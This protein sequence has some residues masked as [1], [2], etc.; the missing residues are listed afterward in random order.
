MAVTGGKPRCEEYVRIA[1]ITAARIQLALRDLSSVGRSEAETAFISEDAENWYIEGELSDMAQSLDCRMKHVAADLRKD[2]LRTWHDWFRD[3]KEIAKKN[4]ASAGG[5]FT[6]SID[7]MGF[8]AKM[9]HI[10]C[11]DNV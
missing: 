2:K 9:L 10:Q 5:P 1:T 4:A 6:S 8:G 7:S 11:A 3:N